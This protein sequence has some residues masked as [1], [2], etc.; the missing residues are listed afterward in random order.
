ME[1]E[2]LNENIINGFYYSVSATIATNSWNKEN[3]LAIW[4]TP[5]Y[6]VVYFLFALFYFH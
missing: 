1:K 6:S 2:V 3:R 5:L 4:P